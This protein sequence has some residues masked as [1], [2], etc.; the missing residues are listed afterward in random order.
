MISLFHFRTLARE[1]KHWHRPPN[2]RLNGILQPFFALVISHENPFVNFSETRFAR[3][4]NAQPPDG[5]AYLTLPFQHPL[6]PQQC[7]P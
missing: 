2:L 1:Q 5:T 7:Q 4:Q 6:K 3:F